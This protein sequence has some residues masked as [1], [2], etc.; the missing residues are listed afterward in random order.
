MKISAISSKITKA[1]DNYKFSREHKF[2]NK[3]MTI[4]PSIPNGEA[5]NLLLE[6]QPGLAHHVARDGVSLEFY[7]VSVAN[8]EQHAVDG[9]KIKATNLLNGKTSHNTISSDTK[10]TTLHVVPDYIV[11][12]YPEDGIQR[13]R[14]TQ[15]EYS[16]NFLRN[17]YRNV[18]KLLKQVQKS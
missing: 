16:D 6:V 3:F 12:D 8:K 7:G 14:L 11:I 17:I 5:R 18:D 13:V 15:H 10:T 2:I 1:I 4:H 9:I